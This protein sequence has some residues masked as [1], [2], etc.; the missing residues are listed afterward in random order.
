MKKERLHEIISEEVLNMLE[1]SMTSKF[2]K[3]IEALQKVQLEQQKLRKAFVAEK[4]PKKKEKLK[5]DIIKMHKI[6]QKAELEFNQAIKVEPIDLD[7]SVIT[8]VTAK[9]TLANAVNAL[10]KTFGGK[11]LDKRYV[12]DYLKSI[13]Q[14][15]RKKPMD[16]V[17]DYGKFK[18]ADWIEDAEYNLQNESVLEAKQIK[19]HGLG[20]RMNARRAVGDFKKGENI[21]AVSKSGKGSF[22]IEDINDFKKYPTKDWNYAYIVK[23]GIL[24]EDV[25]K[26]FIDDIPGGKLHTAYNS[27]KRKTVQARKTDKV[28][29]DGVPVLKY[30]AR[31]S[32]KPSPLPAGKF[33][34]IE[35]NKYGWWYYQVGRTW[36]GIQQKDYGTPPFEY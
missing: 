1:V 24:T 27:E 4:N 22:K 34:I 11:K 3:A 19:P 6:V 26:S 25:W 15:A 5:Q 30:I 36:Y 13:E 2:K 33:K 20:Y 12:K 21:A 9:N 8:E 31:A 16:F 29:D 35:D 23:E 28:W 32:K 14:M 10:T 7:E 17:K 18:N